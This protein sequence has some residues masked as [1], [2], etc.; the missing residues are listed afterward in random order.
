MSVRKNSSH[1]MHS[2]RWSLAGLAAA[3]Q[4]TAFRQEIYSFCVL[5]PLAIVLG[6]NGVE[7]ALLLGS[8]L[9]VLIA[10]LLN[11][12]VE[13]AIDRI[14]PERHPLSG[15]AKDLASAA[16]FIALINAALIWLL[17]LLG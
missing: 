1:L 17:I 11:S 13:A 5:I 12:A 16:V 14:G 8:L 6:H 9:L 4:E 3:W 7:R 10:E 15:R 2:L